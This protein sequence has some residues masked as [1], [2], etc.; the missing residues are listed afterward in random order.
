MWVCKRIRG[1]QKV[2]FESLL[3]GILLPE[4]SCYAESSTTIMEGMKSIPHQC[5]RVSG[6][7]LSNRSLLASRLVGPS[8]S[9]NKQKIPIDSVLLSHQWLRPYHLNLHTPKICRDSSTTTSPRLP[10]AIH[11]LLGSNG[12][13]I[14]LGAKAKVCCTILPSERHLT[15]SSTFSK[16]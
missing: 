14:T 12:L 15:V 7:S 2:Q 3:I 10:L 11:I 16:A 8:C 13:R 5:Q 1:R 4:L 9:T 6:R